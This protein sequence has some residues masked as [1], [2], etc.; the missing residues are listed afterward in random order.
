MRWL[1]FVVVALLVSGPASA[2]PLRLALLVDADGRQAMED[3][4]EVKLG[5]L[6][7]ERGGLVI[8]G[9]SEIESTRD[10][11]GR[12]VVSP[13]S[14]ADLVLSVRVDVEDHRGAQA[15]GLA[16]K[17]GRA[18]AWLHSPDTGE[19][20][21]AIEA[22][23]RAS[24]LEAA[25]AEQA[26]LVQLAERVHER[27]DGLLIAPDVKRIEIRVLAAVPLSSRDLAQL[28]DVCESIEGVRESR[29]VRRE[30]DLLRLDILGE[31]LDAA[32]I[33]WAIEDRTRT[34]LVVVAFGTRHLE[35]APS[36]DERGRR[37]QPRVGALK[38]AEPYRK[39]LQRML[40]AAVDDIVNE[41]L[42]ITGQVRSDRSE[43]LVTASLLER[44]RELAKVDKRCR[45]SPSVRRLA[46][47][48]AFA[49]EV[50]AA[51]RRNS[52]TPVRVQGSSLEIRAHPGLRLFPA[53][54]GH[55]LEH[56]VGHLSIHNQEKTPM[57]V[58]VRA[59]LDDGPNRLGPAIVV[60]P[61]G[62]ARV[63]IMLHLGAADF[64][65]A[66]TVRMR[67]L[68]LVVEAEDAK[69][70]TSRHHAERSLL[71]L[72]VNALD[73]GRDRGRALA[74][75]IDGG[76]SQVR[77]I[78]L[79]AQRA[80]GTKGEATI[81]LL[82]AIAAALEGLDYLADPVH[83]FRPDFIDHV[84]FPTETLRVGGGDCDDLTVLVASIA[85]AAGRR[86]LIIQT[87]RHVLVAISLGIRNVDRNG[88]GIPRRELL[89]YRG[90][91]WLPLESTRIGEGFDVA[92]RA[93]VAELAAARRA[94]AATI[95][96]VVDEVRRT[97][98]ASGLA[99]MPAR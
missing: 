46:C 70:R 7:L 47:F 67:R 42:F 36:G 58:R 60:A 63:P 20:I 11:S 68:S 53:L 34:N 77:S 88:T 90:E 12:L 28:V 59:R 19:R 3:A 80:S 95:R 55:Y 75:F 30:A 39:R 49:H 54:L 35:L 50:A 97:Y 64:K 86:A 44:E 23:G 78:A 41:D 69:G 25:R 87:P 4:F 51:A 61:D 52:A 66:D 8:V 93:A 17:L 40:Q 43:L 79:A 89:D 26:V 10:R 84:Q 94:G 92:R 73:W 37:H 29:L 13:T 6:L 27:I 1:V 38:G 99:R 57:S 5:R 65:S 81:D 83:P 16:A 82:E 85:E 21:A 31:N 18:S 96:F 48:G 91:L 15:V 71:V 62:G 32:T 98:P 33:A 45:E 76:A 72:D 14:D 56:P 74:S 24:A 2:A 22:A 9:A